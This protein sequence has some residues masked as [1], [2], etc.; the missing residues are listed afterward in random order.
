MPTCFGLAVGAAVV[1]WLFSEP[2]DSGLSGLIVR[3]VVLTISNLLFKSPEAAFLLYLPT[4]ILL[5]SG[6]GLI[7]AQ[8]FRVAVLAISRV[9]LRIRK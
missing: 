5:G 7:A 4:V 6:V 9:V 3:P 8:A 2:T 1:V